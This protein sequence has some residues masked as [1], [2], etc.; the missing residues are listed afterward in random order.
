MS[1]GIQ[2]FLTE[3]ETGRVYVNPMKRHV[4]SFWVTTQPAEAVTLAAGAVSTPQLWSIDTQGHFELVELMSVS[5]GPFLVNMFDPATQKNWMNRPVHSSTILGDAARTYILPESYFFNVEDAPRALV[6][7][8]TNLSPL[9]NT[10]RVVG[11]GR[12]IYQR[13]SPPDIQMA[14]RNYYRRKERT[15]VYFFTTDAAAVIP[16]GSVATLNFPARNTDEADLEI[17]K[18]TAAFDFPFEFRI[19]ETST[20]KTLSDGFV[21]VE[22]GFGTAFFPKILPESWLIE[23]NFQVIV[24]AR[25]LAAAPLDNNI[26][27]TFTGRRIYYAQA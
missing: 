10:I 9:A 19:R 7:T 21:R 25:N 2:T 1:A 23:R 26:F 8:Y 20:N 27:L 14:F 12:R 4:R 6:L 24:E 18:L 5:D 22:D 15:S 13:E 16:A 17:F 11:H 3:K